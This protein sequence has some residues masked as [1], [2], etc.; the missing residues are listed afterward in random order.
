MNILTLGHE[1]LRHK[2][3]DVT[4]IDAQTAR[5]VKE[6][7]ETMHLGKGIG[8]AATQV[9]ILERIFVVQIADDI[10]RVFINPVLKGASPETSVYEEGCLSIPGI[11]ADVKRPEMISIDAL[12]E[13]GKPFHLDADGLLAR[14]IQHELDH[15]NG[16]LFIDHLSELKRKRIIRTWEQKFKA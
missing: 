7:L 13:K 6:M 14:V 15:L 12:D 4:R 10:P 5:L 8:L 9:G 2:A 16:V 1:G 11:Y 3:Q